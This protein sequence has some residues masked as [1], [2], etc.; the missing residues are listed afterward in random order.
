[1]QN[2]LPFVYFC[3][4]V[5]SFAFVILHIHSVELVSYIMK[6]IQSFFGIVTISAVALM[7]QTQSAQAF[8]FEMST[9]GAS[10]TGVKT[11]GAYSEFAK[12]GSVRTIDFNNGVIPKT[13]YA[14]Y[15]FQNTGTQSGL[16]SDVYAPLGAEGQVNDSQYLKVSRGNSV[17]INLAKNSNYF[18]LD[19]GAISRGNVF[20]F[21]KGDTLVKSYETRDVNPVAPFRSLAQGNGE[22]AF[23]GQGEG[24]GYVHFRADT[25]SEVFDRIVISQM[26]KTAFESDNH[27]FNIS[28][29]GWTN[30]PVPEP[31]IML[32]LAAIGGSIWSKRKRG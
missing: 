32:G 18:G 31:G 23:A 8:S 4:T 26:D 29:D 5:N 24:N 21:Y 14:T 25:A 16:R 15:S 13:G 3:R 19:W 7:A 6:R 20:T 28:D 9:G 22:G 11:K 30:K 2:T 27:S 17:T 1:M 12:Y 10:P